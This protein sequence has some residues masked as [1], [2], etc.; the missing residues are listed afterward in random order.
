MIKYA[1]STQ[2]HLTAIGELGRGCEVTVYRIKEYAGQV[3]KIYHSSHRTHEKERKICVMVKNPPQDDTRQAST[4]HISIAWPTELLYE[5]GQF[6]G[7]I[8]PLISQCPNIFTLYN[9]RSRM[10]SY[11]GFDWRYLHRT[12]QNLAT[13][14]NALHM[15]GYVMGDVNQKN[16]LVT[17]SALVTLV[18]TDSFQVTDS[19]GRIYRCP[20]GVPEYTPPELQGERLGSVDR[21]AHHDCFGLAVVIF[22]LL[23]EG[24]HPFTGAPKDHTLSVY[25]AIYVHCIK[26][27]IFPYNRNDD[28]SPPPNAPHL[29]TL[30]PE[31]QALFLRC[32]VDGHRN[33]RLRPSAL[34]W[35]EA[36]GRAEHALKKCGLNSSHYYSNHLGECPWCEREKRKPLPVQQGL[37]PIQ[38]IGKGPVPTS[39]TTFPAA[40]TAA[41]QSTL[42]HAQPLSSPYHAALAWL[43]H[44]RSKAVFILLISLTGVIYFGAR[45]DRKEAWVGQKTPPPGTTQI[46]AA[47]DKE[48]SQKSVKSL[49]KMA[50]DA[51]E[52]NDLSL[53]KQAYEKASGLN[54]TL[55]TT[56][57]DREKCLHA[58]YLYESGNRVLALKSLRELRD[59]A[60]TFASKASA[61]L[62]APPK[63][64]RHPV[65][66]S[67]SWKDLGW[68][69]PMTIH[70]IDCEITQDS[71]MVLR[72]VAQ[73]DSRKANKLMFGYRDRPNWFP[74]I[75]DDN[76]KKFLPIV[77]F[78]GGVQEAGN[79]L[80]K[81]RN[82]LLNE[83]EGVEL[84]ITFPV[85]SE[86]ARKFDFISPMLNGWQWEWRI[87]DIRLK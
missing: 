45:E 19:D 11:P 32:F 24:F 49:L 64:G 59:S 31:T 87:R 79:G 54:P 7:Y 34:E 80:G 86:G 29:N 28:F 58:I 18:D 66:K 50:Q 51:Y 74:H 67:T 46:N 13:A 85:P 1:T 9:P 20:V 44:N 81:C 60:D 6:A 42:R 55:A 37:P 57:S 61:E 36:L 76:G 69:G 39:A 21:V 77:T 14:I 63:I 83:N 35:V 71:K 16:I 2:K 53:F 8:M 65:N 47:Y 22:Q 17:S 10:E 68:T 72:I 78:E 62:L 4:P 41:H 43:R 5:R 56:G 3:A 30:N 38:P 40:Q 26:H 25:G 73:N 82:I 48:V 70:L 23:M 15:R 27:G 84:T 33:P 75:L 52:K 12:A